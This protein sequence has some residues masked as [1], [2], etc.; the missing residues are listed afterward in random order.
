M[1]SEPKKIQTLWERITDKMDPTVFFGSAALVI[2]FCFFG[3]FFTETA[4]ALFQSIQETVSETLGWYYML[5]STGLLI[6]TFWLMLGP[7]GHVKLG[8]PDSKPEFGLLSWFAMLFSAGMGIGIVFWGVA[9]PLYHFANP[10]FAQAET[11]EAAYE[12]MR[13]SFFHWGMHPWAIYI[14]L[15]TALAF[16]HF[17]H[18]LPLAPRAVLYPL[19]GEKGMRGPLGHAVDI[20]CT[21]GTLLGVSTS[22]GLGA[23]QTNGGF[24]LLFEGLPVNTTVQVSLI[25]LITLAA[26]ISVVSGIHKGI[27]LLSLLNIGLAAVLLL[28]VFI[29]GPTLSILETFTGSLGLYL[30]NLPQM[31][32]WSDFTGDNTWQ[33]SWTFFYWG[34]WISWSPFVGVFVARISR[35]R[36]IREV[37]F[38]VLL[39][40]VLTTFIWL[41]VFGGTAL[42]NV[43]A[44]NSDLAQVV[45]DNVG[46]SLHA[47]LQELPFAR[48]SM[49]WASVVIILF[50]ITSSDSGSLVDDMVTSGGHPNP[51]KSQRVFW[52]VSEG[53]VAAILLIVGGLTAIQNASIA[54]GSLMSMV[55]ILA[56]F[57]LH[58]A[59]KDETEHR[60]YLKYAQEG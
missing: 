4:S 22:L 8:P 34:W 59:L 16:F 28:Y 27:R 26:T 10:P 21:V 48:V 52:A 37:V 43:I 38:W 7:H 1:N 53:A 40:P 32:L 5:L 31:S 36:T 24:S 13:Y 18:H 56:C 60:G 14:I 19:V 20:L 2:G 44:E 58:K 47:M 45:Q 6:F 39:V 41:S 54:M 25:G 35:G 51:P 49:I 15:A 3:G 11:S 57:G 46:L 17:R 30:Q 9:E 12:A 55:L 33:A 50:F 42:H 23:I 29:M